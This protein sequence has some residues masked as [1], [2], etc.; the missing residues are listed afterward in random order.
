MEHQEIVKPIEPFLTANNKKYFKHPVNG[1]IYS[2]PEDKNTAH[3]LLTG[4]PL[5][6]FWLC[7]EWQFENYKSVFITGH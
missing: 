3:D 5:S 6:A 1:E 4:M 7:S 2:M